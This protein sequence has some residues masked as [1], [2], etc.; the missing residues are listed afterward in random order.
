MTRLHELA[1]AALDDPDAAVVLGDW[2]L[3]NNWYDARVMTLVDPA[4]F[5]KATS[6]EIEEHRHKA[7]T[8][9]VSWAFAVAAVVLFGD[10]ENTAYEVRFG[11]A[12]NLYHWP[13]VA[14]CWVAPSYGTW[15]VTR[16]DVGAGTLTFNEPP[17][18]RRVSMGWWQ[19]T[20][21]PTSHLQPDRHL[22]T[23]KQKKVGLA[24]LNRRLRQR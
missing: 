17:R 24:D 20:L 5:A 1:I 22:V 8:G 15:T 19:P 14:R 9:D 12:S 7:A 3:E 23:Q 4:G 16:V 21:A 13:V 6:V 10:W 18:V 2:V 11:G